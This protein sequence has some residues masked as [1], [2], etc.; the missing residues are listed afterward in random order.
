MGAAIPWI[1]FIGVGAVAI[2]LTVHVKSLKRVIEALD[3]ELSAEAAISNRRQLEINDLK[4][5]INQH[6][7]EK[8]ILQHRAVPSPPKKRK[9]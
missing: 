7:Q 5:E 2:G 3:N 6:K 1:L 9:K 8:E 4:E